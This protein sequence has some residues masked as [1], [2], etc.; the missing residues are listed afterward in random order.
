MSTAALQQSTVL[1]TGAAGFIGFHTVQKL[2]A[3]GRH[4]VGVDNLNSYYNVSLKNARLAQ[5]TS[6]NFTF[7]KAD[8][9]DRP[10]MEK[11]WAEQGPFTEVVHLAAQ[12]GVRYS[13]TNP[14][15]YIT[16]N[17]LGHL[18]ILEMCRHT[19]GF[20]HLVYASSSSVYGKNEKLPYAVED[21]VNRPIS[22]YAATK[23]S[24][25]LFSYT[26]SHLYRIPQTGLRFFTVYGPWGRPDMAPIIFTSSIFEGKPIKV[27]NQGKMKRDFTYIDDIVSG[28]VATLTA[29]PAD[30]GE[31]PC[32]VLNLGNHRSENLMDFIATLESAIGKKAQIDFQEL[33]PGDVLETYADIAETT[34]V[35]GYQPTTTIAQGLPKFIE[36]YKSFYKIA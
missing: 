1:V 8:I 16:S 12:A 34:A 17:C 5:I 13:L 21:D 31:P 15:D 23:R 20:K 10:A 4:V 11:L 33:Q 29:P 7:V 27:F 3:Q 32:R 14:Y 18:T 36:W 22:L 30:T 19:K 9:S 26:Y 35:T 24:D 2:L 28:V 6:A 25:E